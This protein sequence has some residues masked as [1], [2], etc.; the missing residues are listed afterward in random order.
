MI[1]RRH[2]NDTSMANDHHANALL[3]GD[4]F[5]AACQSNMQLR[6]G[7]EVHP[8]AQMALYAISHIVDQ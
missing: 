8:L 1:C 4:A 7:A 6:V 5:L 2:Q 3:H